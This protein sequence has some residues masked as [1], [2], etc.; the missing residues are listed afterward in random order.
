ML[1]G[2]LMEKQYD[3]KFDNNNSNKIIVKQD[4]K[5]INTIVCP[6]TEKGCDIIDFS[7]NRNRGYIYDFDG[8]VIIT[9]N[10]KREIYHKG[11]LIATTNKK[12]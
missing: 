4:G 10:S 3:I 11:D 2:I 1:N 12:P 9:S 7:E 5:I 8:L 6:P